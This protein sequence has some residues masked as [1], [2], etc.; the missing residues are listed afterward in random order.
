MNEKLTVT[1]SGVVDLAGNS[2]ADSFTLTFIAGDLTRPEVLEVLPRDGEV[3]VSET[4]VLSITFTEALL[5]EEGKPKGLIIKVKDQ[6]G[7][8]T[9][10]DKDEIQ[11]FAAEN[12]AE[13]AVNLDINKQYEVFIDG[14]EDF[15]GNILVPFTFK[16]ETTDTIA[17]TL[18]NV[19]PTNNATVKDYEFDRK[20]KVVFSEKVDVFLPETSALIKLEIEEEPGVF[21]NVGLSFRKNYDMETNTWEIFLEN[22]EWVYDKRYRVTITGVKDCKETHLGHYIA[23]NELT[24]PYSWMF[25]LSATSAPNVEPIDPLPGFA[26]FPVDG[27]V[28]MAFDKAVLCEPMPIIEISANNQQDN[29][30]GELAWENVIGLSATELSFTPIEPLA[31]DTWYDVTIRGAKGE[32]GIVLEE[33]TYSFRTEV[34]GDSKPVDPSQSTLL[35]FPVGPQG[36]DVTLLIPED[37]FS[38]PANISAIN[39]A[40]DEIQGLNEQI[41]SESAQLT[42]NV[43]NISSDTGEEFL[44][45]KKASL[46]LPY[47]EEAGNVATFSGGFV[48][49]NALQLCWWNPEKNEWLPLPSNVNPQ[50]NTVTGQID[51]F[52]IYALMGGSASTKFL[53]EVALTTNPIVLDSSR[54]QTTFRF[55]LLNPSR[56]T[57]TLYNSSG[58]TV[59]QLID[60]VEYPIG[61]NAYNWDS[62]TI[63]REL[64][65]GIYIYRL[66]ATSLDPNNPQSDWVSGTLGIIW[67]PSN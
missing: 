48:A 58:R 22:G 21:E 4:S 54:Q 61:F 13:V 42:N 64:K 8:E 14:A 62:S 26:T 2:M 55:R 35:I 51:G 57:L 32:N 52:G 24:A 39:L 46:V 49:E 66:F 59:A 1:L 17:P 45:G 6:Q 34:L 16:F 63:G 25:T 36:S 67:S 60:K 7:N 30:S 33:F 27:I 5:E 28:R 10:Y 15:A 31:Y 38:N 47:I 65:P 43:Y 18:K 53:T 29:I 40:A 50:T 12:K 3:E 9:T 19:L 56:V 11:Y 23:I 37:L 41:W 20:L 44:D